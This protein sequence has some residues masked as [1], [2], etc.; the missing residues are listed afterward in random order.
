MTA[1]DV[2]RL[3]Q[4]QIE[5]TEGVPSAMPPRLM[6]SGWQPL[7]RNA[8]GYAARKGRQTVIV[9][10]AREDDGRVWTHLSICGHGRLPTWSEL[11]E[12]KE[13][14]L[15]TDSKAIQVIPPRSEYV[16]LNPD[17][18]HLFVCIDSDPLPDFTG[19]TGS[20]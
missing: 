20:L 5:R 12:A 9:S 6:V 14:F 10:N 2:D 1:I 16:N 19:G 7:T 4:R 3:R 15:G 8:D 17:V 18:L 13:A 11:V